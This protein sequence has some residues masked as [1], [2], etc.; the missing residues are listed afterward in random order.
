[1]QRGGEANLVFMPKKEAGKLLREEGS[2]CIFEAG[3]PRGPIHERGAER[4]AGENVLIPQNLPASDKSM[5][6][7]LTGVWIQ[8]M[9]LGVTQG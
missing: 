6:C 5:P 3:S 7:L 1:M 2:D 4:G 9:I 8:H